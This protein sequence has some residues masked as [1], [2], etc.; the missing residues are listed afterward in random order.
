MD[1]TI[2]NAVASNGVTDGEPKDLLGVGFRWRVPPDQFAVW[3]ELYNPTERA[4][5]IN[6]QI[7]RGRDFVGESGD[8]LV[9]A[10]GSYWQGV[11]RWRKGA[12]FQAKTYNVHTVVDG[13]PV[14]LVPLDFGHP[15][16][17]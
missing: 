3:I 16:G 4:F 2:L 1:I 10:G 15:E 5:S 9:L 13:V 7:Q 14:R 6:L 8:E 12:G 17:K 11:Y